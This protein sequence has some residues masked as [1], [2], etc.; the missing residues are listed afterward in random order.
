MTADVHYIIQA[1]GACMIIKIINRPGTYNIMH[2]YYIL[3]T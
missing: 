2:G 1:R 3:H